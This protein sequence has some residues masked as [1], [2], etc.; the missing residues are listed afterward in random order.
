L[1]A[2]LEQQHPDS[3]LLLNLFQAY[4]NLGDWEASLGLYQTLPPQMQKLARV[5]QQAGLALNRMGHRDEAVALLSG[6]L[7]EQGP[8][9]ETLGILGRIYKDL[10]FESQEDPAA[11][12]RAIEWYRKGF[13]ANRKD[14]YPGINAVTLLEIR[15]DPESQQIK[16]RLLPFVMAAVQDQMKR[17]RR[18]NYW[19]H[20][21]LLELAVLAGD[22]NQARRCVEA[23]RA[24]NPE[25]WQTETTAN[26]LDLIR[27]ARAR[28]GVE[29]P[30]L[31]QILTD[32]HTSVPAG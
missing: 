23:A 11:L 9:S 13:E 28:R 27:G 1:Q 10:W 12:D 24:N 18:P 30:W 19:D 16:D 22:E 3:P 15:G 6:L 5:R 14:A 29:Q 17:S 20:A 2:E 7:N 21:T 8:N 26:N 4:G 32:L 25:S 31:D